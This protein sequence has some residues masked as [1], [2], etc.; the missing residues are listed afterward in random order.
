VTVADR[1]VERGSRPV[2]GAALIETP[3]VGIGSRAIQTE[4]TSLLAAPAKY[5]YILV[6]PVGIVIVPGR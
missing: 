3:R 1:V 6:T 5:A 4:T 2:V